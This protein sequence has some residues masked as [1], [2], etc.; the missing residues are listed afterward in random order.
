VISLLAATALAIVTQDN[1]SLRA[2]P[3]GGAAQH[4]QLAAGDLLEVRGE[5]LDFLQVYDHRRERAGYVR[6]AQVRA[7][8]ASEDEAPQLLAVVRFLRDTPGAEALGI[9][10]V[11]AYLK[12]APARAI[13][14][15]SFDA[16]GVMAERLARRA[17]MPGAPKATAAAIETVAQYGVKFT[18]LAARDGAMTL[19]YDGDAFKQV[20]A[21]AGAGAEQQARAALALTRADCIDPA[22]PA[23]ERV[24]QNAWRAQM[25][26]RTLL[27]QLGPSL[28]QR[29][30]ARR[31]AVWASV[32]FDR[33]RA[34]LAPQAAAQRAQSE[35]A[36]V[37]RRELAD[38]DRAAYDDAAVRVGASR[39]AAQASV[40]PAA[41]LSVT[42]QPGAEAG[43]TCVALHDAKQTA[44]L[45]RRC[46][47]GTVWTASARVA[48]DAKAA[49]LAVQPLDAWTEL[50]V[51]RLQ[52]NGRW[53]IDALPPA[54]ASETGI[55]S[56]EFA[57]FVPGQAKM[58]VAR[59]SRVA[60]QWQRR[61]E[62]L[63]LD[64]SY[65]AERWASTPQKVTAF[66]RWAD[67]AWKQGS[68]ILR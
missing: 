32:A 13:D 10:Y 43:Q 5:R 44:V 8:R 3:S 17:S 64:G 62:V 67:A 51:F 65:A 11:A 14:A 29:V 58:L 28:T 38:D 19:C 39:W 15:E 60:G 6:A 27:T 40:A 22:L 21:Q 59:E 66:N 42:A 30:H 54:A 45:A 47:Y 12:A 26:D 34:G 35:L 49:V 4:A 53:T 63:R 61:F 20:L 2:A 48:T 31:A 56:I 41:K 25:L 55:G 57:G 1:A 24:A 9:A 18:S 37:D 16:L 33:S 50:W 46:T 68:I 7:V 23:H 36:A 52:R